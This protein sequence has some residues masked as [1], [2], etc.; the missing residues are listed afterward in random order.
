MTLEPAFWA[1]IARFHLPLSPFK[2]K[3]SVSSAVLFLHVYTSFI[4]KEKPNH[5]RKEQ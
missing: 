3:L 4:I 5:F 2:P 1:Q